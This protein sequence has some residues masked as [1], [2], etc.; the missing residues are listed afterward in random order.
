MFKSL[1][2]LINYITT[3]IMNNCFLL[4]MPTACRSFKGQGWNPSH[5]S[6]PSYSSDKARSLTHWATRELPIIAYCKIL[7]HAPPPSQA[8][9]SIPCS[10][11]LRAHS[12]RWERLFISSP[13]L[14][15]FW[16]IN[17]ERRLVP[18]FAKCGL[19]L[20]TFEQSP[21]LM[22]MKVNLEL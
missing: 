1:Y 2:L 5:S 10:S 11:F 15:E 16:D 20:I 18:N 21:L 9:V 22:G 4:A 3:Y 13:A 12:V 6:N 8:P 19:L 14:L 17:G 7:L